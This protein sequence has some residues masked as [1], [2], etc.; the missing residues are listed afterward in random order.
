[1]FGDNH[2]YVNIF[3]ETIKMSVFTTPKLFTS[4][5]K[6]KISGLKFSTLHV[7]VWKSLRQSLTL[8]NLIT[9]D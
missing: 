4:N 8:D 5:L 3:F 7:N 6:V 2:I 1:M 9:G